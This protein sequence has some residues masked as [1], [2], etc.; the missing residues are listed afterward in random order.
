MNDEQRRVKL[1]PLQPIGMGQFFHPT[2]LSVAQIG[3]LLYAPSALLDKKNCH[4]Q[5]QR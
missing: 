1:F 3:L 2:A 5:W 4:Q